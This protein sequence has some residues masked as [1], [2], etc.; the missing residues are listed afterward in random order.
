MSKR[1][2]GEGSIR[3]RTDGRWLVTFPTGLY[4]DNGKREYIYRY[5]A[6]QA[7]AAEILRQL[8]AERGMGI[9]SSKA[10]IKTGE[11]IDKWIEKHKA[12]KLAPATLTSYRNNFRL[13]INPAIGEIPLRRLESYHIQRALDDIGGTVSTFVKNYN[14]IHGALE[15]AVDL[16]M[17][18]NNPCKGVTFPKEE[19]KE[20]R[21]L[22]QEEQ[23]SLIQALDGEYYRAMILT[24]LYAGL[25]MGEGIP[26]Q[27]SDIELV[28]RTIRVNKKAIVRHDYK[29]HTAKQEIQ[30]FCKT[31]SSKR[32]VVITAGLVAILA[33]H[34]EVM[35]Q[36][37]AAL[38]EEWSEDSLVFKNT[39]GNI[40]YSRN[41]QESLYK[42][43]KKAGIEGATMHTLRHT[44]A[45]RCFE[46]GVE[47]KAVSEQ[48][49]HKN[50]KTTY[51]IYVHLLENTKVR[52]IDKLS[53]I[54]K[55]IA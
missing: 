32:T 29:N 2:N 35:K 55:L 52:E 9:S 27:W 38:G 13:H 8:Q 24:Y 50:V 16:K 3:K 10:N 18:V 23:A 17:I 40:V 28:K 5:A 21:V 25:R 43:Y 33:E 54:D 26:L 42:V 47:I 12:P 22:T 4:K 37:A 45:T 36:R 41:L 30:N 15:K 19:S 14:V 46:A 6:T 44:Y 7:E 53:E 48:L 1:C 51:N 20:M 49:G 31:K 39:R 34:K 11:W